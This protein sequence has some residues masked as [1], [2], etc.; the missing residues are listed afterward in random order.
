MAQRR[1]LGAAEARVAVLDCA[2]L[3]L[4]SFSPT[5]W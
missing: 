3:A 5:G 4:A 2:V 1:R